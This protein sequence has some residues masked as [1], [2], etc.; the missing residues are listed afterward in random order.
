MQKKKGN[1][2]KKW[3][4]HGT[5][6]KNCFC[7]L[8]NDCLTYETFIILK[9]FGI[10]EISE[11]WMRYTYLQRKINRVVYETGSAKSKTP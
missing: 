10:V 7:M 1:A 4:P 9:T 11:G 2:M 3:L 5:Y 8:G 6:S